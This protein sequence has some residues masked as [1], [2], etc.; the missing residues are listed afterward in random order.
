MRKTSPMLIG[1]SLRGLSRAVNQD[2][3]VMNVNMASR[4]KRK[5]VNLNQTVPKEYLV[6]KGL[7]RLYKRHG[8]GYVKDDLAV[9]QHLGSTGLPIFQ[10]CGEPDFQS[11]FA[12][13]DY[14]HTWLVMFERMATPEELGY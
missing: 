8:E 1:L 3:F 11:I 7:Y 4:R 13:M 2:A 6:P 14:G 12:L 5:S 9:F 10:P